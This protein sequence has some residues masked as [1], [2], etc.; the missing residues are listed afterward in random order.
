MIR[1]RRDLDEQ[2]M[3]EL[4]E[5]FRNPKD[6]VIILKPSSPRY[7]S[8]GGNLEWIYELSPEEKHMKYYLMVLRVAM[9][10]VESPAPV[11]ADIESS[12][13]Y[14]SG[15]IIALACDNI[16]SNGGAFCFPQ[17]K[18]GVPFPN[19]VGELIDRRLRIDPFQFFSGKPISLDLPKFDH[20]FTGINK[21][22]L[23]VSLVNLR[24]E[25]FTSN[26]EHNFL[27]V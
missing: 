7:F 12:T 27:L 24:K 26:S 3:L 18:F 19:F 23:A 13:C 5:V 25:T 16:I 21:S 10:I 2:Y 17:M 1:I 9:A 15:A 14:G 4:C 20:D 6:D 11:I 8:V 22:T